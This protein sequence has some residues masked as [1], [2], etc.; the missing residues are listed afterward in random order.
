MNI[1]Y[2]L[3]IL[4]NYSFYFLSSFLKGL[5]ALRCSQCTPPA[6]AKSEV[7]HEE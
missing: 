6:H 3:S 4:I 1:L 5:L 2:M 7:P